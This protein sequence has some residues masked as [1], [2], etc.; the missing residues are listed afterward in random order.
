MYAAYRAADHRETTTHT[1]TT[2]RI[3]TLADRLSGR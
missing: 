2:D 1:A 3:A